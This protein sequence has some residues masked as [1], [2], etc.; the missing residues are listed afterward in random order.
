MKREHGRF[1]FKNSS[2]SFNY[3]GLRGHKYNKHSDMTNLITAD[4]VKE[5]IWKELGTT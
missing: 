3:R 4:N 1:G 2:I 5:R